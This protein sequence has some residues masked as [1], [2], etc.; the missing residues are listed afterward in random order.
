MSTHKTRSVFGFKAG[1]QTIARDA[2]RRVE[3]VEFFNVAKDDIV[4][5]SDG[6]GESATGIEYPPALVSPQEW[7]GLPHLSAFVRSAHP[8]GMLVLEALAERLGM[9]YDE[10]AGRHRFEARSGDD[11]RLTYA[12][13]L[14][15][16]GHEALGEEERPITTWEHT[17]YGSLTILF[18]W[19]GGLQIINRQVSFHEIPAEY[20]KTDLWCV[21]MKDER[22]GVGTTY[23]GL[24]YLQYW[25]FD[26]GLYWW[27]ASERCSSSSGCA[28]KAGDVGPV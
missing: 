12:P 21:W 1:G 2:Q 4:A 24:C 22:V 10:I 7:G 8:V 9:E 27:E 19:L 15:G 17:D 11:A 3:R 18:N 25:R 6:N 14:E 28:G 13:G 16:E 26:G 23:A 5:L 20:C